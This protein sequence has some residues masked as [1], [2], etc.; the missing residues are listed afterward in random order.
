MYTPKANES[1]IQNNIFL[2]LESNLQKIYNFSIED[3]PAFSIPLLFY[4]L[5]PFF[6]VTRALQTVRLLFGSAFMK[7]Q[8]FLFFFCFIGILVSLCFLIP[9]SLEHLRTS[10]YYEQLAASV[11]DPE[12]AP[13]SDSVCSASDMLLFRENTVV[14]D[15]PASSCAPRWTV[16]LS[17]NSDTVAWLYFPAAGISLPVV[18][19]PSKEPERYLHT[20]FDGR[21]SASGC[22]FILPGTAAGFSGSE[23]VIYGHNMRNGTMFGSLRKIAAA[24][25]PLKN[26][27]LFL[28]L[29]D[30]TVQSYHAENYKILSETAPF[31]TKTVAARTSSDAAGGAVSRTSSGAA[32]IRA[33][34][35]SAALILCTC[36]GRSDSQQ[37]LLVYCSAQPN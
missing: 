10:R 36:W 17:V 35:G 25:S 28:Y 15:T 29:P 7:F 19:A 9:D 21:S 23:A 14:S 1:C 5:I 12:L 18:Q 2:F 33:D 30:G 34:T 24:A 26:S 20:A 31:F 32:P 22:L 16:L 6:P 27:P 8:K 3:L 37:R 4:S 11:F 13:D